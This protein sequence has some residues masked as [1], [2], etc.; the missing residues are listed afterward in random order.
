MVQTMQI[1]NRI[2]GFGSARNREGKVR[3]KLKERKE[4]RRIGTYTEVVRGGGRE[5]RV[6]THFPLPSSSYYFS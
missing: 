1:Q 6:S 4:V 3:K 5:G 2:G